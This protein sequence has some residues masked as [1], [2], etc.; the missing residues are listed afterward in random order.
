MKV[1]A[2]N[3]GELAYNDDS[4]YALLLQRAWALALTQGKHPL[5]LPE[6]WYLYGAG[7]QRQKYPEL[8]ES[9]LGKGYGSK[10]LE[11]QNGDGAKDDLV[12]FDFHQVVIVPHLILDSLGIEILPFPRTRGDAP[13]STLFRSPSLAL[14]HFDTPTSTIT[15][16]NKF[17]SVATLTRHTDTRT[18]PPIETAISAVHPL[19]SLVNHDCDPNVYW[20]VSEEGHMCFRALSV[21]LKSWRKARDEGEKNYG[22]GWDKGVGKGEQ[23]IDSYVDPGLGVR[24]RR[25]LIWGVL[26]GPCMCQRCQRELGQEESN[27]KRE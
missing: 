24:E 26:G 22:G 5:E 25:K 2:K 7:K 12:P 20:Q 21:D 14:T 17:K 8:D 3:E 19:Y 10:M 18:H 13:P 6:V 16:L 4:I 15:L 27:V 11:D 23:L 1:D 9:I